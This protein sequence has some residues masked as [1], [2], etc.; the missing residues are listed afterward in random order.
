MVEK[1]GFI[2]RPVSPLPYGE[3]VSARVV[4]EGDAEVGGPVVCP[5]VTHVLA[6]PGLPEGPYP[7]RHSRKGSWKGHGQFRKVLAGSVVA[8]VGAGAD[9]D[10]GVL[11]HLLDLRVVPAAT[12][13][14]PRVV[15][16]RVGHPLRP[17]LSRV[18][19]GEVDEDLL[20]VGLMV[21]GAEEP[22]P[23]IVERVEEPVLQHYPTVLAERTP[24]VAIVFVLGHYALVGLKGR[25]RC[26]SG[27]PAAGKQRDR[28]QGVDEA[29]KV[30]D[31]RQTAPPG[32]ECLPRLLAVLRVPA[33]HLQAPF[34][35]VRLHLLDVAQL[36]EVYGPSLIEGLLREAIQ[37][38][39]TVGH[40]AP[41]LPAWRL[42]PQAA[43]SHVGFH[44]HRVE[45]VTP[46]GPDHR[47][48][49]PEQGRGG[50]RVARISLQPK[51]PNSAWRGTSP[52]RR[53]S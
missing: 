33:E 40:H 45:A 14:V 28:V 47:L 21:V 26:F 34:V 31:A 38:Q 46:G 23:P 53:G 15:V 11:P 50:S 35:P 44:V 9:K 10:H 30:P 51:P 36:E 25:R 18:R 12:Q 39:L 27:H 7:V 49:A 13:V 17:Y 1:S 29:G 37:S 32:P 24:V 4:H 41:G 3:A 42:H 5:F 22:A 20:P 43:V 8:R 19:L 6:E 48:E 16:G 2:P 52:A